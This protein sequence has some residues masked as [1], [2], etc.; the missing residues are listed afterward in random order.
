MRH[1]RLLRASLPLLLLPVAAAPRHVWVV[2]LAGGPGV[3]CTEINP[4]VA[5]ATEC[6]R[7]EVR[8]AGPYQPLTLTKGL[9]V[10][11]VANAQVRGCTVNGIAAGRQARI[12]GF[13]VPF[14][15]N[16]RSPAPVSV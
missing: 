6:D 7:I 14:D 11:A 10:E 16:F 2:D 5:A 12:A 8:G 9:D 3:H 4:A 1:D 15:P 13:R